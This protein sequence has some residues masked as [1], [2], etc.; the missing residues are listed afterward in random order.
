MTSAVRLPSARTR[1]RHTHI[2][3]VLRAG[4]RRYLPVF[5]SALACAFG[6]RLTGGSF[7]RFLSIPPRSATK[8]SAPQLRATDAFRFRAFVY[9]A[10]LPFTPLAAPRP[11]GIVPRAKL[12]QRLISGKRNTCA[13]RRA[14]CKKANSHL[15]VDVKGISFSRS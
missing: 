7:R 8:D 6:L 1:T 14:T 3:C 2:T 4:Q 9:D 5:I 12:A 10:V 15:Y 13:T 11:A